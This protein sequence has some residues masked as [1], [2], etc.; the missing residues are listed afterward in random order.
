MRA[1]WE[2]P[3]SND[4]D[5]D[6]SYDVFIS[7]SHNDKEWV[8]GWLVPRLKSAGLSVCIDHEAFEIGVPAMVNM[9][10][11]AAASRHVLLV[12]TPAWVASEWT[13]FESLLAQT[14]DPIG[15]RQ[16]TLPLLRERCTIPARISILTYANLTGAEGAEAELSKVIRAIRRTAPGR[17]AGRPV[18]VAPPAPAPDPRPA[19][20]V[21][22]PGRLRELIQAK[23]RRLHERRLQEATYGISGDPSI[24]IEIQ[25]LERDIAALEQ[26]LDSQA[27]GYR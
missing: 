23:Q 1:V 3:M 20:P 12:L 18:V 8:R 15:L 17:P 21:E 11:A 24:R 2:Q 7:Y 10:Q 14:S 4:A 27:G 22:E 25:D 5:L 13:N 9:E 6:A 19:A 16:R 26:Q